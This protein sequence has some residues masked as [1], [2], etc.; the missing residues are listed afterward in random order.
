[1]VHLR[2]LLNIWTSKRPEV[3]WIDTSSFCNLKCIMCPQHKGLERQRSSMTLDLF[4]KIIDQIYQNNPLVKLYHSGEPF[5]NKDIFR[6]IDYA[7]SRGCKTMIHTNATL[8]DKEMSIKILDSPLDHISFSFDGCN[9][10][11]YEKLRPGANFEKVKSQIEHFLELKKRRC[12]KLPYTVI[13]ILEMKETGKFLQ[14]FINR[15]KDSD[16]DKVNIQTY[17]TWLNTVDD[18]RPEKPEKLAYRPCDSIFNHCSIL[19][20][21]TVVPCSKDVHGRLPLGNIMET[22]FEK[23]WQGEAYTN[24]RK[25]HLSG[26]IPKSLICFECVDTWVTKKIKQWT[27]KTII[28]KQKNNI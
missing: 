27:N 11:V 21:G 8:L 23:I 26:T 2:E 18:H 17:M 22:P 15:W 7:N 13:E 1:M 12:T 19:S 9:P 10:E 5:L 28:S 3:Y 16:V 24:L 14:D 6:M 4:K 25:Q 20:N